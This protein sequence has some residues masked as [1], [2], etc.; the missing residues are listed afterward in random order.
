MEEIAEVL[1]QLVPVNEPILAE[2][3]PEVCISLFP[4]VYPRG[5]IL[6]VH[7]LAAVEILQLHELHEKSAQIDL[8]TCQL[9]AFYRTCLVARALYLHTSGPKMCPTNRAEPVLAVF[10]AGEDTTALMALVL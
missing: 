7:A 4:S 2:P 9:N 3:P 6:K 10:F 1:T 5:H 8:I